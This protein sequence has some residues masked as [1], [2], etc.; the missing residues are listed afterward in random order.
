MN[1]KTLVIGA[2]IRPKRYSYRAV[3]KLKNYGHTVIPLG[4]CEG[5]IDGIRIEHNYP[6]LTGIDTVTMYLNPTKQSMYYDYIIRLRPD[7]IIFNPGT[8]NQEFKDLCKQNGIEVVEYCTLLL[9]SEEL[10]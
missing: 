2:S 9:L 6:E 5:E 8:E 1:K 7:R 4:I 3:Q 10:F